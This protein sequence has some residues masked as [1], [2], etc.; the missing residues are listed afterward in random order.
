M[1]V[2][3]IITGVTGM[4]GEG[5]LH[6]CLLHPDVEQ[7]LVITRK[8]TSITHPKLREVLHSDFMNL[9]PIAAEM[10]GYNACYFCL[11]VTSVGKK[12][13]EYTSLTYDLTLHFAHT[14]AGQSPDATFCYVSGA[15]TDSTEKGK[16]M[17]AR[18]KGRTENDLLRLFPKAYMFRP[19]YMEATPGMQHTNNYYK[20]FAW[21][22][23]ILK[24]VAPN[25]GCTL[26][27]VGIAMIHA[28]T[29]GYSSHIIEV[30]DIKALAK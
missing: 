29:R 24:V 15:G 8:P 4:V 17:W 3:A 20:Y 1:K 19:G 11:G 13:P 6:E 30:K 7:V 23:P 2:R 12:E 28:S 27:E 22:I 14:L 9:A 21:L 18:V 25:T 16:S 5:V 10:K 26:R